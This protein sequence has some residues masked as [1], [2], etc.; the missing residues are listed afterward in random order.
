MTTMMTMMTI[1]IIVIIFTLVAYNPEELY[2]TEYNIPSTTFQ[3]GTGSHFVTQRPS[4][5]RIQRPGDPVDPVTL[6]YNELQMLTLCCRQTF[7]MDKRFA[8]FYRGLAFAR[9][10]KVKF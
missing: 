7:A 8:I 10:W 1:I 3:T 4:A 9:F 5:P 2:A 6:F